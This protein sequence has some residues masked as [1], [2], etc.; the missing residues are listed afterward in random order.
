LSYKKKKKVDWGLRFY[1]DVLNL[2]SLHLGLWENDPLTIEGAQNAQERYTDRLTGLI[3]ENVVSVLD[4]GCGTGSTTIKLKKREYYVECVNPDSYQEEI[5][6][7]RIG[8]S[9]SFHRTKFE[10]FESSKKFDLILMSESSQYLDTKKMVENVKNILNPNGYLLIADY[11]RKSDVPYYK[12]C[13]IKEEFFTIVKEGGLELVENVDITEAV[14][15]NLTL[16]KKIYGEYGL[17][18][19]SLIVDYL[20]HSFPFISFIGSKLFSKKIKKVSYYMYEHTP[21]KLDEEKFRNN[22]EY[23]FLLYRIK[24]V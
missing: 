19:V 20:T 16:G 9:I 23:L 3:P 11:F 10:E 15:P 1:H 5:F 24:N 8:D 4:V 7:K 17:P 22:M 13:K 12:T 14:L 18:V 6:K 2:E 21:E